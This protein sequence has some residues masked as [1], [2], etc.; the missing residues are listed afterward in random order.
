[1]NKNN[2]GAPMRSDKLSHKPHSHIL[3]EDYVQPEMLIALCIQAIKLGNVFEIKHEHGNTFIPL[4]TTEENF[5]L[6][7]HTQSL[8]AKLPVGVK[9]QYRAILIE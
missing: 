5:L 1:M 7:R 9:P 2:P 6:S 3:H 8:D 4:S